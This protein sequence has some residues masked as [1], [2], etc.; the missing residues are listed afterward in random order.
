MR[1]SEFIRSVLR[2]R[3]SQVVPFLA[4]YSSGCE[5][6]AIQNGETEQW[7]P[8]AISAIAKASV[9][10]GH[11]F[12]SSDITPEVLAGLIQDFNGSGIP[13]PGQSAASMLTPILHEQFPYQESLFEDMARA[14]VLLAQSAPDQTPIPW[15]EVLGIGLDQ[16]I[17]ASHVLHQVV[18][19]HGGRYAPAILD[20]PG[21]QDVYTR[22]A[23]RSEIEVTASLLTASIGDLKRVRAA[24]DERV[25]IPEMLERYAFN[26]LISHPLVDLGARGVWAPQTMFIPRALLGVNL[27]YRGLERWG[28]RFADSLGKR[29]ETYVGKQLSLIN[30]IQ[31]HPEVEYAKDTHS[32]DWLWVTDE[33]VILVECKAARMPLDAQAGGETLESVMRRYIGHARGQIDK[34]ARLIREGHPAFDHIPKD[35]QIVGVVTTAEPFYLADTPFSGFISTGEVPAMTMS[36]RELEVL[37]GCPEPEAAAL[38]IEQAHRGDDGGRFIAKFTEQALRRENPILDD[39][40][41]AFDFLE[42]EA[43]FSGDRPQ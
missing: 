15:E 35:R 9:L 21:F 23:P 3:P 38:V 30:N 37:A 7:Y 32:I 41:H 12:S 11:E 42:H 25:L 26:P 19:H 6:A 31:L 16:A 10:R 18:V 36:L 28:K 20:M 34:T 27:Y 13:L 43:G 8:W 2:Y 33:A 17:R 24:A 1:Y 40:W 39:A 5:R 14:H 22:V 29:V 4:A